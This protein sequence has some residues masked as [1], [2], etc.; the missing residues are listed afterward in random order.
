MLK[1][2]KLALVILGV[3]GVLS[4]S[5]THPASALPIL[6]IFIEGA[7]YDQDT[8]S[9]VTNQPDLTLWVIGDV[10]GAGP[11]L[12]VQL[13]AAFLTGETGSVSISPTQTVL[14]SDPSLSA[15]PILNTGVGADGTVPVMSSGEALP[16]HGIYGSGTSFMQWGLGNMT[17]T[18][19]A[20]GDFG[21][22]LPGTFTSSGQINAY[23]ISISG[24]S[25]IHFDTFNHVES[26]SHVLFGSSFESVSSV[27]EPGSLLLLGLGLGGAFLGAIRRRP[28][29]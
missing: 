3:T 4:V 14:L 25:M 1:Q 8:E 26:P 13:T 17:L 27:P 11:I 23:N 29:A 12:D 5:A 20:I 18:D 9:W 16:N 6:Q 19:S 10:A 7:T 2:L 22:G 15:T 21:N 24:Y 28:R